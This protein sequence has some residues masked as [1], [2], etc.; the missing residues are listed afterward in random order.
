MADVLHV[1]GAGAAELLREVKANR[2]APGGSLLGWSLHARRKLLDHLVKQVPN[3][4]ELVKNKKVG[5]AL[6][7]DQRCAELAAFFDKAVEKGEE[8]LV[9]KDLTSP[10]LVQGCLSQGGLVRA[11]FFFFDSLK[12]NHQRVACA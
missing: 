7:R 2:P 9:V 8:G 5:E 3:R 1:S 4:L 11:F 10:Y 6:T 12:I